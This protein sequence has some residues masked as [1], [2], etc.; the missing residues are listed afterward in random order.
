MKNSNNR[1][2]SITIQC[3]KNSL[4]FFV[5]FFVTI[6]N[7]GKFAQVKLKQTVFIIKRLESSK[8]EQIYMYISFPAVCFNFNKRSILEY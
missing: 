7:T 5:V 4:F 3:L 2:E 8:M 6:S 1:S